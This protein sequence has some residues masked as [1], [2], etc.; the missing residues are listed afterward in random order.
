LAMGH[1]TC[2]Q[3]LAMGHYT[4]EQHLAMGHYTC[5]QHL[6]MGHYTCEQHLAMRHYTCE[7]HLTMRHYTCEQHLAMRHYTCEQHLNGT[8][9]L[10]VAESCK[11]R[12]IILAVIPLHWWKYQ[13]S[14]ALMHKYWQLT[15]LEM[16][17][18][19]W[20][21]IG[22]LSQFWLWFLVCSMS[23]HLHFWFA[24]C[25]CTYIF[26]L[27]HVSAPTFHDCLLLSRDSING[28]FAQTFR[29]ELKQTKT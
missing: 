15:V 19:V 16:T 24:A 22:C 5:E 7:Q 13:F 14:H 20:M 4:C 28:T 23:L 10:R 25:L 2:E 8:N 17:E 11:K 12:T 26:G 21:S 29:R 18:G 1:Y 9:I 27:Q 3:H 6:A